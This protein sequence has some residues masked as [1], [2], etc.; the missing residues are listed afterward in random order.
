[1]R[2]RGFT[3]IELLVVVAIITVLIAIL[4]PAMRRAREAAMNVVCMS[5][6]KQH[7]TAMV[8]YALQ[9]RM[10]FYWRIDGVAARQAYLVRQLSS[11]GVFDITPVVEQYLPP[12]DV[13]ACPFTVRV[14]GQSWKDQYPGP[15]YGHQFWT[16]ELYV[17]FSSSSKTYYMP[18]GTPTTWSKVVP[19]TLAETGKAGRPLMGDQVTQSP[20]GVNTWWNQHNTDYAS[21][22]T[23][24]SELCG[25]YVYR[26]LSV[27]YYHHSDGFVT[28][29][30]VVPSG[31]DRRWR[32]RY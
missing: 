12:S 13:Y 22:E 25:N 16:Y 6:L 30:K 21:G 23:P 9:N 11:A 3:L 7:G 1:M 4:L 20:N 17:N 24:A 28:L 8:S 15:I 5:N 14:S 26:D 2:R 27:S 32:P 29:F 19:S 18:D 10:W 31:D